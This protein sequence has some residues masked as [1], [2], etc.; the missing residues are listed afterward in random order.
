MPEW[1]PDRVADESFYL[2][3]PTCQVKDLWFLQCKYL[4]RIRNGTF[5]DVGAHDGRLFSNTWGLALVG[6][7][8]LLIEPL[9][10]LADLCRS[11]HTGHKGVQVIQAAIGA[12][13]NESIRLYKAGPLTTSNAALVE[14][15]SRLDW[16]RQS[17]TKEWI[18]VAELT[19]DQVLADYKVMPGFDFL[20]IDVEGNEYEVFQG[21]DLG[22]WKPKML[23]VEIVDNHPDLQVTLVSDAQVSE[24]IREHGYRIVY[25][26]RINTVFVAE[27]VWK[28]RNT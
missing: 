9:P 15:Y 1:D 6:W 11:N 17:L 10:D 25:K 3:H 4:G 2:Q 26:D 14:E 7:S 19:L 21:F 18:D 22:Y 16:A 8:G 5:V 12:G 20:S 23:V 13:R 28:E 24:M 27:E